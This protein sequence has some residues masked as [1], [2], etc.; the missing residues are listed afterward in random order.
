VSF[1][2]VEANRAFAEKFDFPFRLLCDTG[3]GLGLA[4][5]ACEAADAPA[6]RR[7]TYLIDADGKIA[8]VWRK[9][10]VKTHADD[11]LTA[12]G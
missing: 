1:D 5:G 12:I 2:T 3:R 7:I 10:D 8:S 6:P 11:V 4:Y 9:V